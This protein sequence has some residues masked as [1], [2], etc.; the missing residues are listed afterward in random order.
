MIERHAIV[1]GE[2]KKMLRLC[3]IGCQKNMK[4]KVY[5]ITTYVI[6]L[7]FFRYKLENLFCFSLELY[8]LSYDVLME[9]L[10]HEYTS[11]LYVFIGEWFSFPLW[12]FFME[13]CGNLI[14][15]RVDN[16]HLII[17][18]LPCFILVQYW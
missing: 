8:D 18:N 17:V 14:L 7:L 16:T 6:F 12:I 4:Q 9:S 2:H 13:F 11:N 1:F 5:A 10:F 15:H 3:E